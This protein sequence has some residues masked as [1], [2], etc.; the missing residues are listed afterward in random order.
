M[1]TIGLIGGMSY[2]STVTYYELLNSLTNTH[3]GDLTTPK[4]ILNSL[5]FSDIEKL[6]HQNDWEN[7][8]STLNQEAINSEMKMK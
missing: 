7:L 8:G 4:I 6:Q 3:F 1:K 5:N 2:T